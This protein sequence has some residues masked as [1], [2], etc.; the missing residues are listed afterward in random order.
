MPSGA[1]ASCGVLTR[2]TGQKLFASSPGLQGE[3][4]ARCGSSRVAP[5]GQA[6][7]ALAEKIPVSFVQTAHDTGSMRKSEHKTQWDIP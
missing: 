2:H 7:R 1:S 4:D 5:S 3:Q 6:N